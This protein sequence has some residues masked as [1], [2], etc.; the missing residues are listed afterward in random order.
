MNRMEAIVLSMTAEERRRPD[1]IKGSRRKRV[2]IGSGTQVADVGRMLKGFD[3]AQ[4]MMR[5]MGGGGGGGK[6][7]RGK[8]KA[9][10]QLQKMDPE[11]L[12]QIGGAPG[13]GD[14]AGVATAAV[15][16]SKNSSA[17]RKH[18]KKR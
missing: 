6:G 13:G 15:P 4:S 18:K 12:N 8:V 17:K 3:Q 16:K 9:L 10:R 11:M 2:A 1:I 14:F 7:M 5:A